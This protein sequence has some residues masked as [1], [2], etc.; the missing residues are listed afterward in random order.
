MAMSTK[1]QA[2][3]HD[4]D[5]YPL[6][7]VD[8]GDAQQ[9][10]QQVASSKRKT[11]KPSKAARQ[12]A[13]L[14]ESDDD[15]ELDE[16]YVENDDEDDEDD[17]DDDE[18][19]EEEEEEDDDCDVGVDMDEDG[20]VSYTFYTKPKEKSRTSSSSSKKS[21]KDAARSPKKSKTGTDE[22][23]DGKSSKSKK[24]R[25][26]TEAENASSSSSKQAKKK[27]AAPSSEEKPE[28]KSSKRTSSKLEGKQRMAMEPNASPQKRKPARD[29]V[30]ESPEK[31]A[32]R[33]KMHDIIDEISGD[34]AIAAA[35]PKKKPSKSRVKS[36]KT[37]TATPSAAGTASAKKHKRARMDSDDEMVA[38]PLRMEDIHDSDL[39]EPAPKPA[40]LRKGERRKT[41]FEQDT[42]ESQFVEAQSKLF[43][44]PIFRRLL[45]SSIRYHLGDEADAL[46]QIV[47]EGVDVSAVTD[48]DIAMGDSQLALDAHLAK[49][50]S[51]ASL[52][53]QISQIGHHGKRRGHTM[54]GTDLSRYA[55]AFFSQSVP[56]TNLPVDTVIDIVRECAEDFTALAAIPDWFELFPGSNE[57]CSDHSTF[58]VEFVKMATEWFDTYWRV[59]AN[60]MNRA[61]EQTCKSMYEDNAPIKAMH[62]LHVLTVISQLSELF[63]AFHAD[64]KRTD[65]FAMCRA[66]FV[67]VLLDSVNCM[68]SEML[69]RDKKMATRHLTK[70]EDGKRQKATPLSCWI[71]KQKYKLEC[72][73]DFTSADDWMDKHFGKDTPLRKTFDAVAQLQTLDN[74]VLRVY[75]VCM[76][77]VSLI[78]AT[79][80]KSYVHEYFSRRL[81]YTV[82]DMVT[83]RDKRPIARHVT[84]SK[85]K[86]VER[87]MQTVT[88]GGAATRTARYP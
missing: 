87:N 11:A 6:D 30:E 12:P 22:V 63:I 47:P 56:A 46:A 69:K 31:A 74:F 1:K 84:S 38:K 62:E 83:S 2:A 49:V 5:N 73:S 67:D 59:P 28:K 7:D 43:P 3:T 37:V 29:V 66:K 26:S 50:G 52:L 64:K 76:P 60:R 53:K 68:K 51:F 79:E 72:V 23:V 24:S 32:K 17:D 40:K 45:A 70:G 4:W 48:I 33:R 54:S 44:I 15:S 82:V 75:A 25:K 19:I 58:G 16:D 13:R 39:D 80:D 81:V 20:Q 42:E 35:H 77:Y 36:T 14:V 86:E 61:I 34:E 71:S 18:A 55:V 41:L 78:L 88:G 9:Q 21:S 57:I 85:S 65:N 27:K 10:Q 8:D